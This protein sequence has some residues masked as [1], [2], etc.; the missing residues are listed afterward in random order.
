MWRHLW[1]QL[2][3]GKFIGLCYGSVWTEP[4][5]AIP[6]RATVPSRRIRSQKDYSSVQIMWRHLLNQ[7]VDGTWLVFATVPS[8]RNRKP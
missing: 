3:D 2:V 5:P 7:L 8:G 1:N 4:Y 6:G